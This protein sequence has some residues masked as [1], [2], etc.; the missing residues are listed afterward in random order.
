MF[1]QLILTALELNTSKKKKKLKNL[2][3][4]EYIITNISRI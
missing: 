4:N 3:G 1:I 2:Q